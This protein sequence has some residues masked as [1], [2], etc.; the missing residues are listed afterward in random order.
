MF[1]SDNNFE[2]EV[3]LERNAAPIA[4]EEPFK[5]LL[6]GDWSGR[7]FSAS[8][9]SDSFDL[10]S[11]EIDRDNFEDV[12][13]KFQIKLVLDLKND[14]DSSVT[15]E[16][17]EFDDF[18]PDKIFQQ[19][20]YFSHLRDIRRCLLNP[21]TFNSAARE[22]RS[23]LDSSVEEKND[24]EDSAQPS[25]IPIDS[26]NLLDQILSQTSDSEISP[27][28]QTTVK[29]DLNA[30]IGKLVKP[31]IVQTDEEEQSKLLGI[32]DEVTG[33]L[34]REI[35]HHPRFQA[36]ESAWRGL[37]FLVRR[38]ETN[39]QLKLFISDTG[40]DKLSNHLK[41]VENLSDSEFYNFINRNNW[42]VICGNFE[43]K[44]DVNDAAFLMR[45]AKIC[46]NAN[47]PFISY[48]K[49]KSFDNSLSDDTKFDLSFDE[50]EAKLWDSLRSITESSYLGFALPRFLARL[51]FGEN[52]E[53]LETFS[54][55]ELNNS[56]AGNKYIW[57][58]PVFGCAFLLAQSF[59]L[60][61]WEMQSNFQQQIDDLPFHTYQENGETIIKNSL[62]FTFNQN[63]CINLMDSG[64]MTFITFQTS[65][66]VR[67]TR[68]QSISK[69]SP[70][71]NGKWNNS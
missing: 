4:D 42:S 71:L 15:I 54:F 62:E 36:M 11:I 20:P 23:W 53:P 33:D 58:N 50:V 63:E 25:Q 38:T 17:K 55:D 22:V 70:S 26:D 7:N 30:L 2:T 29:S 46:G 64:F 37:Y 56:I 18:H 61:G 34:M 3:T 28:P 39:S 47:A 14:A 66:L 69:I 8:S 19:L 32:V 6:L 44:I 5:I 68:F 9:T 49:P 41:S 60:H 35:L 51:P 52:T 65:D 48:L 12:L 40:K 21:D 24:Q 59:S 43:F 16:I 67:L 13:G 10:R 45:L 31:F 27:K 1:P 57:T